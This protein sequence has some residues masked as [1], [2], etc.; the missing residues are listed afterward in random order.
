LNC[1]SKVPLAGEKF[2]DEA[3]GKIKFGTAQV[4]RPLRPF[5]RPF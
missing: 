3:I 4:R 1:K 5:W 2:K